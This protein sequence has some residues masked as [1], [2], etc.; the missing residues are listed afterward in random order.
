M[1]KGNG[2]TANMFL[3]HDN[4]KKPI[5]IQHNRIKNKNQ[6]T[7]SIGKDQLML[8]EFDPYPASLTST[9]SFRKNIGTEAF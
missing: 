6:L 4:F 8:K 5:L 7:I 3:S 1:L 9:S 2:L